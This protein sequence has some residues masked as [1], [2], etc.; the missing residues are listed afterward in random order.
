MSSHPTNEP[1]LNYEPGSKH[2][3]DLKKE[4]NKQLSE[5]LEIPCIVN[6]KKIYTNNTVTQV[7]PHNHKHILANVHLAGKR[8]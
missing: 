1:I 4:I 3:S 5:V 7:V 2:K 6:G 8:K